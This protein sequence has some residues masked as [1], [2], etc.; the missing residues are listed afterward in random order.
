MSDQNAMAQN[1]QLLGDFLDRADKKFVSLVG[2]VALG[3]ITEQLDPQQYQNFLNTCI[4]NAHELM[5]HKALNANV[6]EQPQQ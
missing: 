4:E 1:E 2:V 5:K 6:K 3:V